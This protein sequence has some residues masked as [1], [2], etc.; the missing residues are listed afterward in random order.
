[1]SAGDHNGRHLGDGPLMH[2]R[3]WLAGLVSA[4]LVAGTPLCADDEPPAS[5]P[6]TD[7]EP[8]SPPRL[9]EQVTV[10]AARTDT[11]IGST[12]ASVAVLP[13]AALAVTAAP[14]GVAAR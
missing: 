7:E 8:A 1:M 4:A 13:R 11:R 2:S 5:P 6:K 12:P 10:T 14:T 3:R 9:L